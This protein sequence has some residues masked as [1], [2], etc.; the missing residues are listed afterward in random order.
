MCKACG[1]HKNLVKSLQTGIKNTNPNIG[2]FMRVSI[3]GLMDG[4]MGAKPSA[5]NYEIFWGS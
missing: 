3:K 1:V 5:Y 2:Y 4:T